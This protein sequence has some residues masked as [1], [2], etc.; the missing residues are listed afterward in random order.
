MTRA[1]TSP[2]TSHSGLAEP[3]GSSG[4]VAHD[5]PQAVPIDLNRVPV[6]AFLRRNIIPQHR[7][8]GRIGRRHDRTQIGGG[9]DRIAID[10]Q[11]SCVLQE[12]Q[13]FQYR[14]SR[15]A[16]RGLIHVLRRER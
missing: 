3:A 4:L 1:A 8:G 13:R 15:A 10:D 14:A 11:E 12:V 6:S 5:P 16:A 2:K 7:A 9:C